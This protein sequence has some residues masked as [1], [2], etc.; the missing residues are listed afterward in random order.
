MFFDK[1][2]PYTT[3]PYQV[4]KSSAKRLQVNLQWILTLKW[5]HTIQQ[6]VSQGLWIDKT[7]FNHKPTKSPDWP[8]EA[9]LQIWSAQIPPYLKHSMSKVNTEPSRANPAMAV[10]LCLWCTPQETSQPLPLPLATERLTH[11]DMVVYI[12][13]K[14]TGSYLIQ[15]MACCLFGAKPFPNPLQVYCQLDT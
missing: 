13:I 3:N 5:S 14:G 1:E 9:K 15:I 12:C 2:R 6:H 7:Q 8:K 4:D 11:W 10:P